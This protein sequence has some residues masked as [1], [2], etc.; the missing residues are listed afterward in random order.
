[1]AIRE[2][3]RVLSDIYAGALNKQ[4]ISRMDKMESDD[5]SHYLIYKVLGISD[6]EGL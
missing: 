1:M 6:K 3:I 5:N 4:M 2:K